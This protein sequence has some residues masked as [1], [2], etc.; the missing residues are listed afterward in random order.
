[1]FI[2][3]ALVAV[4]AQYAMYYTFTLGCGPKAIGN[5]YVF[6]GGGKSPLGGAA[7]NLLPEF[8]LLSERDRSFWGWPFDVMPANVAGTAAGAQ[9]GTWW[10]NAGI[11]FYTYTYEDIANSKLTAYMRMNYWCPW[12]S[13]KIA[14][15]DGEGP[16]VTFTENGNWL[17]N[18]I[19]LFFKLNQAQ[20]YNIYL[21]A[22]HVATVQEVTNGYPSLTINNAD[23]GKEMGSALLANRHVHGDK[24]QWQVDNLKSTELP[25][26]V[27]SAISLPF[28]FSALGEK[29][30]KVFAKGGHEDSKDAPK[31]LMQELVRLPGAAAVN[32][33]AAASTK[34]ADYP[35][36]VA[37]KVYKA[38]LKEADS[39]MASLE[40]RV[41][42]LHST[43][44]NKTE[45]DKLGEKL[46]SDFGPDPKKL[47]E[48]EKIRKRYTHHLSHK[49]KEAAKDVKK[50]AKVL[51]KAEK[52]AG[53]HERVYEKDYQHREGMSE[54]MEDHAEDLGDK[55]EDH[56]E[57]IYQKLE[58]RFE[59]AHDKAEDE[60]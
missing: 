8:S 3:L 17:R 34:P 57:A 27:A 6:P 40:G 56:I 31:F 11:L 48:A 4:I 10:R 2:V 44:R 58:G 14:R 60:R 7:F 54:R 42:H 21:D 19:R 51:E 29:I 36:E 47:R 38:N 9:V 39:Q 16:V 26:F 20:S 15:C 33:T 55:A 18:K 32:T 13:Y 50:A 46:L 41:E 24:D 49:A 5:N 30:A 52:K 59:R 28:A 45:V 53:E 22:K 1:M 23:S 12:I 43:A 37:E 35:V 25:F